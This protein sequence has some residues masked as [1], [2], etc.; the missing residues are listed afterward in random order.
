[1]DS[2]SLGRSFA[3]THT[4]SMITRIVTH[5]VFDPA[6]ITIILTN[7]LLIGGQAEYEVNY[8]HTADGLRFFQIA[9]Y[10]FAGIFFIELILRVYVYRR[11]FFYLGTWPRIHINGWNV[12]DFIL[13]FMSGVDLIME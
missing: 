4:D 1:M 2:T 13:V 8:G 12:F 3:P 6:V 7:T 10:I 5:R 11:E 9:G